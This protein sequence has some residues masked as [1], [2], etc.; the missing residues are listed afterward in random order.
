M[1]PHKLKEWLTR[2][3]NDELQSLLS[4]SIKPPEGWELYNSHSLIL[5]PKWWGLCPRIPGVWAVPVK[6]NS[7]K[8]G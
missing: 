3:D 7:N 5:K 1:Y 6:L 4:K 8:Q 2:L